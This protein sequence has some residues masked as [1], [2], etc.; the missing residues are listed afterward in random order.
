PH[1]DGI[2][3]FTQVFETGEL[4]GVSEEPFRSGSPPFV[5]AIGV[6][7]AFVAALD[8]HRFI[9]EKELKLR[10]PFTAEFGA[11]GLKDMYLVVPSVEFSSG[12]YA[13]PIRKDSITRSFQLGSFEATEWEA[14]LRDFFV[15]L[16][17]LAARDRAKVLTD[18]LVAANMIP[19]R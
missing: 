4:W 1:G 6:E 15:D 2:T 5:P 9:Y 8:N 18:D 19:P 10:P 17:D 7:K 14:A 13:G 12:E 11:V 3:S 16:Y